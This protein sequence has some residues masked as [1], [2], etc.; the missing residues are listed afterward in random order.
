MNESILMKGNEAI[1]EGLVLAGCRHYFGYPITPQTEI[2]EYLAK[3]LPEVDGV[4]LQAESEIAAINMVYGAAA[5]GKRA[6]TT[7]SSPGI[8]LKQ[9]GI[10]SIASAELPCVIVNVGRGGPGV[11]TIQGSQADYFQSTKGGGH[12]DYRLL[13]LAPNSVQ[14][15][16]DYTILAFDKA[17]EYRT[18][19][20]ILSDGVIG[21]MMEPVTLPAPVTALP[22]KPWSCS[23]CEG[24]ESNLITTLYLQAEKCEAHN[25][26]LQEKYAAI[27][28]RET[29]WEEIETADADVVLVA[30]GISSRIGLTAVQ[31]ARKEGIKAGLLRPVTLWPFPS[32]A[33]RALADKGKKFLVVEQS[34]GQMVDDVRLAVAEKTEVAFHGRMGGSLP[35]PQDILDILRQ[36]PRQIHGQTAGK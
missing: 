1:G 22:P 27:A 29:R 17:D 11:G 3:R 28:A 24:R 15:M 26:A 23:G 35:R 7:S 5:A 8:S 32:G 19:V 9:E 21:Q 4:F 31:K 13:V 33:I 18:P 6:M 34:S 25:K 20:L 10:S 14:E 2:P 36:M 16:L 12:G 30:Y